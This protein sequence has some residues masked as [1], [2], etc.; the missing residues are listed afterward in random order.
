MHRA[1]SLGILLQAENLLPTGSEDHRMVNERLL[2]AAY[3]EAGHAV[4]YLLFRWTFN[5]VTIVPEGDNQGHIHAGRDRKRMRAYRQ[6]QAG[7]LTPEMKTRIDREIIMTF[8]GYAAEELVD[9]ARS[10][11]APLS[12][13][14]DNAMDIAWGMCPS[15]GEIAAYVTRLWTRSQ[16]W[17]R[18]P[19]VAQL[20][21]TLADALLRDRVLD[22]AS[23]RRIH[24]RVLEETVPNAQRRRNTPLS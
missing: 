20:T 21:E 12:T 6:L 17:V 24:K 4:V 15:L 18:T 1:A 2:R 22:Y 7:S 3:H 16:D 8:A 11:F 10:H 5:T 13:D 9:G 23:C 14:R 19:L